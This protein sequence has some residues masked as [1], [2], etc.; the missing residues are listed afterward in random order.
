VLVRVCVAVMATSLLF[1]ATGGASA[2]QAQP[3][4]D[5][6]LNVSK[7]FVKRGVTVT[8]SAKQVTEGDRYTVTATIKSPRQALKVTMLKFNPPDY[9]FQN[10]TWDT[11]RTVKVS[12]RSKV[13][14]RAVAVEHNTEKHRV[15]VTYRNAKPV[16][17]K[18]AIV[19][20]WRWIPL[21]DY[22]PYY[23]TGGTT[24]GTT[25]INGKAYDGWGAATYSHVGA[26][27]SRFTPGRHCT[28]F[29]GV[30]GVGDI[31]ADGSTG[32]I[33][34]TADDKTVY[35]SPTLTPGMSV[36]VTI[37]LDAKPYRLGIQLADTTPGGTTGRDAIESWPVIGEPA[38]RCTG[39]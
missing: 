9:S 34:F 30:L 12:A 24:F 4:D 23:E 3:G 17:S 38:L 1:A 14:F 6:A 37:P 26:W 2:A 10:P 36:P 29:E 31:S 20:V 18:P 13:E 7:S 33:G 16:T 32:S 8:A 15:K 27:E 25:T 11:V 39:V 28:A 21:S 19:T 35:T 5:A 22:D